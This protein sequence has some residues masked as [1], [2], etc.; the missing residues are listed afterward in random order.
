MSYQEF[1]SDYNIKLRISTQRRRFN[2]AKTTFPQ[3]GQN[4]NW[5]VPQH[6]HVV[7]MFLFED[8]AIIVEIC[9]PQ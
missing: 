2:N 5:F 9:A 7:T 1:K 3:E 8:Y 4:S 6:S